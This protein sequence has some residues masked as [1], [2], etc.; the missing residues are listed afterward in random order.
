MRHRDLECAKS[1]VVL[2][3]GC[4]EWK[5]AKSAYTIYR[6]MLHG[7]GR[8]LFLETHLCIVLKAVVAQCPK[9]EPGEEGAT[10]GPKL[11]A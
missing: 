7:P 10:D 6:S 2:M 11:N 8:K 9:A 5:K 3:E 4:I 1:A